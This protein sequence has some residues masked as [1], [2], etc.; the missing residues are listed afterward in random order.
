VVAAAAVAIVIVIGGA[1]ATAQWK[2]VNRAAQAESDRLRAEL[3]VKDEQ[4]SDLTRRLNALAASMLA[5]SSSSS[6]SSWAPR[7]VQA[8]GEPRPAFRAAADQPS[9]GNPTPARSPESIF[10]ERRA[11]VNE[12][13]ARVEEERV[14]PAWAPQAEARVRGIA[15]QLGERVELRDV[16][17]RTTLCRAVF[18]HTDLGARSAAMQEIMGAGEGG[19]TMIDVPIEAEDTSVLYFSR[20]SHELGVF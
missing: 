18:L 3:A 13:A 8:E 9:E 12:L 20:E 19:Q 10:A 2:R 7:S 17:C 1:A 16:S 6:S 14:D 4:I 5:S 15:Q 11:Q